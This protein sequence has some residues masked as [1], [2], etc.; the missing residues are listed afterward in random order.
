MIHL[1]KQGISCQRPLTSVNNRL[2]ES[3]ELPQF[4]NTDLTVGGRHR[5]HTLRLFT[6]VQGQMWSSLTPLE[7]ESYWH[8][9]AFLARLH[10]HLKQHLRSWTKP[11]S[12]QAWSLINAPNALDYVEFVMDENH[13]KLARNVLQTF[14]DKY[15]EKLRI[16]NW[17]PEMDDKDFPIINTAK[18]I[19]FGQAIIQG[20]QCEASKDDWCLTQAERTCLVILVAVRFAQSLILGE[21]TF[22]VKDPGNEYVMLTA[23]QGGWEKL[24]SLWLTHRADFVNAWTQIK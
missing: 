17:I 13:R 18:L 16:A 19:A 15:A 3:I 22:R 9:G 7:T 12:E 14:R 5:T 8:M 11:I 10:R 6:F 23:K 2:V 20:F 21:H 24:S 4:P 1:W